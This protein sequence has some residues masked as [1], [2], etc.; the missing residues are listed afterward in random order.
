MPVPGATE[1]LNLEFY[2]FL[3][4][5]HLNDHMWLKALVLGS[6]ELEGRERIC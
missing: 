5:L 6:T 2:L 1:E 4:N 3:F